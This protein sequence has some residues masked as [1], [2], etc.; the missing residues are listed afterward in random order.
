MKI[1]VT[2]AS[3]FIG[4]ALCEKLAAESHDI[5][6]LTR[7]VE[8]AKINLPMVKAVFPWDPMDS[9]PPAEA[10]DGVD[11]IVHLAGESVSG[12]WNAVKK[13]L[14]RE[15]RVLGT[16]NLVSALEK[17]DQKPQILISGSAVGYYGDRG[18]EVL[19]E[20][21]TPGS[22]F[23]SEVCA[24]WEGEANGA[25]ELGLRVVNLRVGIVMGPGGALARMLP[26]FKM[27]GGG[28]LGNG[29]Q[30]WAWVHQADVVGLIQ[31]LLI[32]DIEGPVNATSPNPVQQ[33]KFADILGFVL[34]RP[35][36]M[37]APAFALKL[38]LGEFSTELLASKRTSAE[39]AISS[40][41]EFKYPDLEKA[42]REVLD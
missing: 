3:G 40:G 29:R 12:R 6:V 38:A 30:W 18:D 21:A 20:D 5:V 17:R 13:K 23:F 33:K 8:S 22:D 41:Y 37:P 15:S 9:E 16:R 7:N 27:G 26:I 36:F 31:H 11:A 24:A 35:S 25:K 4:T 42:L 39:K 2:G 19:S 1:L 34:K 32:S 28:S 14:V 10:F